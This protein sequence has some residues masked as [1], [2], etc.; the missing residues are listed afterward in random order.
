MAKQDGEEWQDHGEVHHRD[1]SSLDAKFNYRIK[2]F[3]GWVN[4]DS[5]SRGP[6]QVQDVRPGNRDAPAVSQRIGV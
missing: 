6:S 5:G 4:H 3:D 1:T 2:W